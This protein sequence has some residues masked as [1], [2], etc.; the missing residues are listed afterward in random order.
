MNAYIESVI[1]LIMAVDPKVNGYM[2]N[3][4]KEERDLTGL[5]EFVKNV[6]EN[7]PN[8]DLTKSS[9]PNQAGSPIAHFY[10]GNTDEESKGTLRDTV[11]ERPQNPC[12]LLEYIES[13]NSHVEFSEGS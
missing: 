11:N 9:T 4:I 12:N 7:V 1:S 13:N 10:E 5:A 6:L 8:Q 3:L 2:S